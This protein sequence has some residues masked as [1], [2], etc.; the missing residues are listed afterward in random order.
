MMRVAQ[1]LHPPTSTSRLPAS[2]AVPRELPHA[3]LGFSSRRNRP[4]ESSPVSVQPDTQVSSTFLLRARQAF[5]TLPQFIQKLLINR[6][7]KIQ[8]A[9]HVTD[10]FQDMTSDT[11]PRGYAQEQSWMNASACYDYATRTIALGETVWGPPLEEDNWSHHDRR[12][13]HAQSEKFPA[14]RLPEI[15]P[16]WPPVFGPSGELFQV[17]DPGS[18]LRHEVGHAIDHALG[19]ISETPA[20]VLPLLQ[21]YGKLSRRRKQD[22]NY[23]IQPSPRG[24]PT[25]SG[26]SEAFAEGVASLYGGGSRTSQDFQK[27]FPRSV[28]QIKTILQDLRQGRLKPVQFGGAACVSAQIA[29]PSSTMTPFNGV[30]AH[31]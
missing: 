26:V 2:D 7:V 27:G 30:N 31:V 6:G 18:S 9:P 3:R 24:V 15:L 28:R 25:D 4:T 5:E 16:Y 21:D 14:N 13:L 22:L 11:A 19:G 29:R 20:F 10:V 17:P 1:I 12:R 23:Y 8:L